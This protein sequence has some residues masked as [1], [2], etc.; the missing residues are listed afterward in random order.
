MKRIVP[1]FI[2][3]LLILLPGATS[4]ASQKIKASRITLDGFKLGDTFSKVMRRTPYSAPC[5]NDAIDKRNRRFMVYGALPCRNRAFPKQTTVMFYIGY[6][7]T[8]KYNQPIQAIAYLH[9]SYFNDKTPFPLKPGDALSKTKTYFPKVKRTFQISRKGHA[10]TVLEYPTFIYV[11]ARADRIVG[12]VFGQMPADPQNE[13]WRGLMQM[14]D[15]YTP[16]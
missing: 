14:Y 8:D 16:K 2:L 10:L 5:D 4:L 9:G 12:F 6:S 7:K 3:V 11:L 15:R 1:P 13:Q